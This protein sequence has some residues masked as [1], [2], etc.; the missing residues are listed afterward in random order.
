M[1]DS[2]DIDASLLTH[3][4]TVIALAVAFLEITSFNFGRLN[5]V[6]RRTMLQVSADSSVRGDA[7]LE[8][9]SVAA[10]EELA[11]MLDQAGS[12]L[13]HALGDLQ[14]LAVYVQL[15]QAEA[16]RALQRHPLH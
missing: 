7:R 16:L 12:M 3:G 2:V 15:R 10:V 8:S 6:A 1:T 13:A 11:C 5:E 9:Q 14:E 4:T